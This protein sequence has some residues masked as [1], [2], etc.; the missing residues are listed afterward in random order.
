M[1]YICYKLCWHLIP[2]DKFK[3]IH[4]LFKYWLKKRLCQRLSRLIFLFTLKHISRITSSRYRDVGPTC[5]VFTSNTKRTFIAGCCTRKLYRK[6]ILSEL[7][8]SVQILK[9]M[10][11][12]ALQRKCIRPPSPVR[13]F[14]DLLYKVQHFRLQPLTL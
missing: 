4:A 11:E 7:P 8:I 12:R 2:T 10:S 9:T 6:P 3:F 1:L 13:L 14:T 5:I